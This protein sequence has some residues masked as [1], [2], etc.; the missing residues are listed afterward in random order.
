MWTFLDMHFQAC[1]CRSGLVHGVDAVFLSV[2]RALDGDAV[3]HVCVR[4]AGRRSRNAGTCVSSDVSLGSSPEF[5]SK[6]ADA[7]GARP[8][9]KGNSPSISTASRRRRRWRIRKA[10]EEAQIRFKEMDK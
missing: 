3:V 10:S 2:A 1:R 9:L 4:P 8:A 7:Q 5:L 6:S